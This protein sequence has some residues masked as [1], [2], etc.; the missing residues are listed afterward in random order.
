[1]GDLRDVGVA[2]SDHVPQEEERAQVVQPCVASSCVRFGSEYLQCAPTAMAHQSSK[3]KGNAKPLSS[4]ALGGIPTG[5]L[6]ESARKQNK[7]A[8]AS[9]DTT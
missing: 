9:G 1:M 7:G 4:T 8:G 2:T 3:C 6:H 5:T